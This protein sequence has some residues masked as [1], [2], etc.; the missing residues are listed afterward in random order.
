MVVEEL[1]PDLTSI[2]LPTVLGVAMVM[3]T[4][5][6]VFWLGS[7]GKRSY[8]EAKAQASRKASEALKEK[9]KVSPKA[10]KP[11]KNFRKKKVEEV[12]PVQRK[13]ILK[14]PSAADEAVADR[15]VINKVEFKLDDSEKEEET[16]PHINPPT[17]Y[18][19]KVTP[20]RAAVDRTPQPIFEEPEPE[21]EPLE[22]EPEPVK[23]RAEPKKHEP[24][25]K[26]V[27]VER[28]PP[29]PRTAK[30][31]VERMAVPAK[32]AEVKRKPK[33][34]KPKPSSGS[35]GKAFVCR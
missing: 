26:H 30:E 3:V 24:K 4:V 7:G 27:P 5:A 14:V 1:P 15:P 33:S 21:P 19:N 20:L 32:E 17:P 6:F 13:G 9:D 18:P 12:E 34:Q 23:Q 31:P 11:R 25:K 8:E 29:K 22:P 10:K 16:S 2:V 35:A 28:A